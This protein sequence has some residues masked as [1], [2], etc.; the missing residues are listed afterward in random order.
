MNIKAQPGVYVSWNLFR[1]VWEVKD[2]I[3]WCWDRI[4]E[5]VTA[6]GNLR[7]IVTLKLEVV[8]PLQFCELSFPRRIMYTIIPESFFILRRWSWG[9]WDDVSFTLIC[10]HKRQ[11]VK[12]DINEYSSQMYGKLYSCNTVSFPKFNWVLCFFGLYPKVTICYK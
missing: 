11:S 4:F 1:L 5:I 9:S 3:W 12:A 10:Q 7:C 8:S 6:L 2:H